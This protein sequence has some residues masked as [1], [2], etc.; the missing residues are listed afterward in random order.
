MPDD[1]N[2]SATDTQIAESTLTL[3]NDDDND[4]VEDALDPDPTDPNV[5]GSSLSG[6]VITETMV[7]LDGDTN[8][9]DNGYIP[10]DSA[11]VRS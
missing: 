1:W 6:K 5:R 2:I 4:G 10:N 7:A 11:A 9:A 8:N 3:D